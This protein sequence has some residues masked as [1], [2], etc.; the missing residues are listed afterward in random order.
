M[1]FVGIVV[2][3]VMAG[4]SAPPK[5]PPAAATAAAKTPCN[6]PTTG[7]HITDHQ[8]CTSHT[9]AV[10]VSGSVVYDSAQRF[11]QGSGSFGAGK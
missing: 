4:C 10:S 2:A 11:N 9:G 8:N 3:C 7:S 1:K 5:D 6:A